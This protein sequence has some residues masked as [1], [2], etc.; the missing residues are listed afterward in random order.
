MYQISL[1]PS[2]TRYFF[3]GKKKRM[4]NHLKLGQ[5]LARRNT[6]ISLPKI[7]LEILFL[8][9]F[10]LHGPTSSRRKQFVTSGKHNLHIV[11][12]IVGGEQGRNGK[13]FM[14]SPECVLPVSRE[15]LLDGL[16]AKT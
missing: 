1:L 13:A 11:W 16:Q 6:L 9:L 2:F 3:G 12:V 5:E 4:D 14:Q 10:C 8:I 7:D 15:C